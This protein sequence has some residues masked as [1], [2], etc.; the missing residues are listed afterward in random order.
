MMNLLQPS[1]YCT[2][3]Q[4]QKL[5]C[6][7]LAH[8]IYVFRMLLSIN[9]KHP[10]VQ[11]SPIVFLMEEHCILCEEHNVSIFAHR[12]QQLQC[13]V[14]LHLPH[15]LMST[16]LSSATKD[17]FCMKWIFVCNVHLCWS[18]WRYN[19]LT[20]SFFAASHKTESSR[21]E[22]CNVRNVKWNAFPKDVLA[23]R[24]KSV[25]PNSRPPV[26]PQMQWSGKQ[27]NLTNLDIKNC[28]N[29]TVVMKVM[30]TVQGSEA[31]TVTNCSLVP[32][33]WSQIS[34][35]LHE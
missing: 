33:P 1:G 14:S 16:V 15:P 27:Y 30:S 5:A 26:Y 35:Q 34:M 2:C 24:G 31:L 12:N 25:W 21:S 20:V 17:A 29:L 28:G 4:G 8:F 7:L 18:S 13:T 6:V 23:Q 22:L 19:K 10:P 3:R 9:S 11:Y 32:Q